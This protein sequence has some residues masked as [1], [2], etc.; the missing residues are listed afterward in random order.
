M[1]CVGSK[2]GRINQREKEEKKKE[3]IFNLMKQEQQQQSEQ[4]II[5][6]LLF[7]GESLPKKERKEEREMTKN[8]RRMVR[9]KERL[10]LNLAPLHPSQGESQSLST[11]LFSKF[12]MNKNECEVEV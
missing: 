10:V 11:V 4:C 9:V 12:F 3:G 2:P 1:V 7:H 5:F 8:R 6:S